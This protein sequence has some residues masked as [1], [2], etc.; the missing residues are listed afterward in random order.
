[1]ELV[2]Y[3]MHLILIQFCCMIIGI[4]TSIASSRVEELIELS[5]EDLMNVRISST[6][7]F[8]MPIEK[9]PGTIHIIS[10]DEL[11]HLPVLNI[12]DVLDFYIPGG[13]VSNHRLFGTLYGSR[14]LTMP[15]NASTLFMIDEQGINSSIGIGV[16]SSLR[17]PLIGDI[18]QIEVINGPCSIVHGNGPINGFV[19]ILQKTGLNY[20]GAFF[21]MRYGI[22]DHLVTMETGYGY[23][24]GDNKDI[25]IYTGFAHSD[26]LL[27]SNDFGYQNHSNQ[28]VS[29]SNKRI[30]GFPEPSMKWSLKL[31]HNEFHLDF[32]FQHE[33]YDTNAFVEN[34]ETSYNGT[35][36][37]NP[38][39][40]YTVS[41]YE[42]IELSFPIELFDVG[43]GVV[44]PTDPK[45]SYDEGGSESHVEA[46][47]IFRTTRF[48]NN[49]IAL[50][51]LISKRKFKSEA[52]YFAQNPEDRG[53]IFNTNWNEYSVFCENVFNI[54][55]GWNMSLG[56]R[57]DQ[58]N[59]N[60]IPLLYKDKNSN[61][62]ETKIVFYEPEDQRI[63]TTRF[64]TSYEI[65]HLNIIK[66]S[67]QE[68]FH[69]PNLFHFYN[70]GFDM[71]SIKPENMESLELNYQLKPSHLGVGIDINLYFNTYKY[72]L[73]LQ[74]PP[75][76][77]S[78]L[79]NVRSDPGF[80][81]I[82]DDYSSTGGEFIVNY[83]FSKNT[84][85][86]FSYGY[87]IPTNIK[88]EEIK[89]MKF[90]NDD[91]SEWTSFP[92][93]LI[94]THFSQSLLDDRMIL[95]VSMIYNSPVDTGQKNADINDIYNHHRII[96]NIM[97]S[98][99]FHNLIYIQLMGKNI[100]GCDVLPV[101]YFN[102]DPWNGNLGYD[103]TLYYLGM[104]WKY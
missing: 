12:T 20:P 69:Y 76:K 92:T 32:L 1:M 44:N 77:D 21:Q 39:F 11:T 80:K 90:V 48:N 53:S 3:I 78:T 13:H 41:P 58:I 27:L 79:Q 40:K 38:K 31:N 59:Y 5:L 17:L 18:D 30:L 7:F 72:S 89:D 63:T 84:H 49:S 67:F 61:K 9:A 66:F 87:S 33:R 73:L 6:G 95:N 64:S 52:Y 83:S 14:G 15:D 85:F 74:P 68:G 91:G 22:N 54:M 42:N 94:K 4:T 25:Y 46:K 97:L 2:K 103:E 70:S 86:R 104:G 102:N 29:T 43:I 37:I 16:N 55:A 19:N 101:S 23:V 35:L 96:T 10:N 8:D 99:T 65:N 93:H 60:D 71:K 34:A 28:S 36:A 24:Y 75:N 98:Y 51:A 57:Y 100:F 62:Q 82:E 45:D 56:I 50:G 88:Q 26:G 81:N 47:T